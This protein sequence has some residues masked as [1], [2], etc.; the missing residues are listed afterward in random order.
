[1]VM[2]VCEEQRFVKPKFPHGTEGSSV[3]CKEPLGRVQTKPVAVAKAQCFLFFS[4]AAAAVTIAADFLGDCHSLESRCGCQ[5]H[6]LAICH[7]CNTAAY[8]T[9][10]WVL[11]CSSC[12]A[13]TIAQS[14]PQPCLLPW[15]WWI[16]SECSLRPSWKPSQSRR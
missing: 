6:V 5:S 8:A 15:H 3:P 11:F 10:Q 7:R 1:M 14:P 2:Q 4:P 13:A 16:L 9:Q 12:E